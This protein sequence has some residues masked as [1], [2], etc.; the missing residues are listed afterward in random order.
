[1]RV[2]ARTS[3]GLAGVVAGLIGASILVAPQA[4]FA[5]NGVVLSADPSLMSEVR[6]PGGLLL[7]AGV[8]LL[9]QAFLSR[10][11]QL[12]LV[13]GAAVFGAYG[14]S[15]L[16]SVALDGVPSTSLIAATAVELAIAIIL[17]GLSRVSGEGA[18]AGRRAP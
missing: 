1:M 9:H 8:Y 3:L 10:R 14:M 18:S 13:V 4:V 2:I 7:I 5:G 6:A 16:L 12:A 17:F 15:R 11:L